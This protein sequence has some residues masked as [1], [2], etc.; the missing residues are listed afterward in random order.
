MNRRLLIDQ[1]TAYRAG[2]FILPEEFADV[3]K[4]VEFVQTHPQCF[5]RE[6]EVGHVTGSAWILNPS[7]SKALLTHHKKLGIW[8]QLGGHADGEADVA[9]V[10]LR[11]GCEESGLPGLNQL[12]PGIFDV[13][14][15]LIPAGQ[16]E[17]AHLHY[18]VRF[19]FDY[20]GSENIRVSEE[21][22]ELAWVALEE[23][24]VLTGERSISRMIEK[25]ASL[26][27]LSK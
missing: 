25:T 19:A 13:D 12:L 8:V 20:R 5:D 21:S 11:E 16:H 14:I 7:K 9:A 6:L 1:L 15:H 24:G 18:D 27:T 23:I 26:L 10:A 2:D 4:T 22:K 17:P 3:E